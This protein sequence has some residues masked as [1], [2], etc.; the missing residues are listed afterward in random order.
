MS[1]TLRKSSLDSGKAPKGIVANVTLSKSADIPNGGKVMKSSSNP[2]TKLK[3]S[4]DYASS[5]F[6]SEDTASQVESSL[7]HSYSSQTNYYEQG[8]TT[9][10]NFY[11]T[12]EYY[13]WFYTKYYWDESTQQYYDYE[14]NE[15]YDPNEPKYAFP[16]DVKKSIESEATTNEVCFF[17]SRLISFRMLTNQK[18]FFHHK[19]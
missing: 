9:E 8:N 10:E 13:D 7:D 14:E 2:G 5:N 15:P 19:E 3:T 6:D 17:S 12:K 4:S 18:I 16:Q 1:S 11:N